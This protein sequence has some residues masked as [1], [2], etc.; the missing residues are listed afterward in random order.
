MKWYDEPL[1]HRVFT[2][3]ILLLPPFSMYFSMYQRETNAGPGVEP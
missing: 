1:F 3:R 2:A